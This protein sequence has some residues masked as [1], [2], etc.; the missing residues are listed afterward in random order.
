MR[1]L[2]KSAIIDL[3]TKSENK[4]GNSN[5]TFVEVFDKHRKTVLDKSHL[6]SHWS[7]VGEGK[8]RKWLYQKMLPSLKVRALRA[9]FLLLMP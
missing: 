5:V 2:E 6:E 4:R 7:G 1:D 8:T 9:H 3:T